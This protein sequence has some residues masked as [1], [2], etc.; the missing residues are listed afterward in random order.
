MWTVI[1]TAQD[2]DYSDEICTALKS[3]N[4]LVKR[5]SAAGENKFDVLVPST[6]VE[7]AHDIMIDLT[8]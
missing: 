6:E 4:I 7:Q 8:F 3:G 1:Y 5:I 2:K